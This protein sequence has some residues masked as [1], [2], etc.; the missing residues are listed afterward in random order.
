MRLLGLALPLFASACGHAPTTSIA[1]GALLLGPRD[2]TAGDVAF[3]LSPRRF[4]AV[5]SLTASGHKKWEAAAAV[6]R[7]PSFAPIPAAL[8]ARLRFALA[9]F[10]DGATAP[11]R[12]PASST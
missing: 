5:V 6:G 1:S 2:P 12:S 8:R 10:L 4:A 9:P 3:A 7:M 11:P